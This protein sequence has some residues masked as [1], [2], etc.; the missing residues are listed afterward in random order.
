M[1]CGDHSTGER[2]SLH[3]VGVEAV[4]LGTCRDSRRDEGSMAKGRGMEEEHMAHRHTKRAEEEGT[5]RKGKQQ[6]EEAVHYRDGRDSAAGVV[7]IVVASDPSD[8]HHRLDHAIFA[9]MLAD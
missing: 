6:Q 7:S 8:Q 5:G 3:A 4:R 1:G 9:S 2:G